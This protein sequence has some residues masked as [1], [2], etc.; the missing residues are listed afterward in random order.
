MNS[1]FV[2]FILDKLSSSQCIHTRRAL[3]RLGRTEIYIV[4]LLFGFSMVSYFDRTIMSIAG[5]QMMRDFGVSPTGMGSVYSAF[6]L[7]YAL[8]ML[9]G[10]LL[11]DRW[12]PRR[13]LTLMGVGSA[14]FTGL[15]IIG[16]RP[17]LGVLIGVVP[18]LF[19]IR[20]GLGVVTAP[21]YPAAHADGRTLDRAGASRAVPGDHDRRISFRRGDFP[22]AVHVDR[23]PVC[24][25]GSL[26]GGG[27]G[28]LSAGR[29]L[30]LVGAGLSAGVLRAARNGGSSTG[31]IVGEP[32][33]GIA[34]CC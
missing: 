17:G 14:L 11:T 19:A 10:G 13:T 27:A 16:G 24:V 20:F 9:P 7:G 2:I 6:I 30:V 12:G 34:I 5:P 31:T 3:R 15:T 4:A 26:S 25:A 8:L 21:L 33:F 29:F 28:H 18:A 23:G 1:K 22:A 32:C